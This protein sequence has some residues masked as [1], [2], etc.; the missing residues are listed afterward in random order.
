MKSWICHDCPKRLSLCPLCIFFFGGGFLGFILHCCSIWVSGTKALLEH[1]N[2]RLALTSKRELGAHSYRTEHCWINYCW[3][4]E[5]YSNTNDAAHMHI[6]SID[7]NLLCFL[8]KAMK[9]SKCIFYHSW[10]HI[11]IY[12]MLYYRIYYIQYYTVG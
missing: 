4:F 10:C 2:V 8:K 7:N 3:N 12:N 1:F 6:N 11:L 5:M 9:F